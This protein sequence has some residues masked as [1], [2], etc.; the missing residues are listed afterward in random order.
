MP[1]SSK[2]TSKGGAWCYIPWHAAAKSQ[3][4]LSVS[5]WL[6]RCT[7]PESKLMAKTAVVLCHCEDTSRVLSSAGSK[8]TFPFAIPS[9]H[10]LTLQTLLC[11]HNVLTGTTDQAATRNMTLLT[12]SLQGYKGPV[13]KH[14]VHHSTRQHSAAQHGIAWLSTVQRL[15]MVQHGAAQLRKG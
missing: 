3:Q 15:S 1:N 11:I 6:I 10:P 12:T 2:K 5:C 7:L 4:D 14:T 9:Q 13:D 8:A